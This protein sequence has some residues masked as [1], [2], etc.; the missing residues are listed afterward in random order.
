MVHVVV[1]FILCS[2]VVLIIDFTGSCYCCFGAFT[3][4]DAVLF[5]RSIVVV[6][7]VEAIVAVF[8]GVVF[9]G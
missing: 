4:V 5:L 2:L 8:F 7:V 6:A 9:S 3:I 1:V